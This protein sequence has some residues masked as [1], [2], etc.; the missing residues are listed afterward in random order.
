[1]AMVC[2]L[3][4]RGDEQQIALA[5][6]NDLFYHLRILENLIWS[7]L[8]LIELLKHSLFY[9]LTVAAF[10]PH[11]GQQTRL[12]RHVSCVLES[13]AAV[14]CGV[15]RGAGRWFS[16]HHTTRTAFLMC[17]FFFSF[18]KGQ[19][20]RGTGGLCTH[21]SWISLCRW[22]SEPLPHLY[23]FYCSFLTTQGKKNLT[24]LVW[25]QVHTSLNVSL[26]WNESGIVHHRLLRF[27]I[28]LDQ[29]WK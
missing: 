3:K 14:C 7:E 28:A 6:L 26:H 11:T 18:V 22:W 1:M 5:F 15:S 9:D 13:V 21:V 19:V 27:C 17:T 25:F 29:P 10:V 8:Y 4:G 24:S 12:S 2:D 23:S 20:M 16:R